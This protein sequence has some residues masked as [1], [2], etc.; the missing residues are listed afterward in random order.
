MS[1]YGRA[2]IAA[3]FLATVLGACAVASPASSCGCASP[4]LAVPVVTSSASPSRSPS[5]AP[6]ADDV[7]PLTRADVEARLRTLVPGLTLEPAFDDRLNVLDQRRSRETGRGW[8]SGGPGESE[9]PLLTFRAKGSTSLDGAGLGIVILFPTPAERRA[10]QPD[11]GSMSI[12][13]SHA[14]IDWDGTV[15]S[16]W[17]GAQNVLVEVVL[18]GGTFGGRSP[19]PEE[20]AYPGRILDALAGDASP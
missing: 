17:V 14:R 6:S 3:G 15:H 8:L 1:R 7:G 16:E 2:V 5:P 11:F 20:A 18:T 10:A 13:G 4:L 19:T 9:K 12:Q